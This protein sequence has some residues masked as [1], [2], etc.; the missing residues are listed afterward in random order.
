MKGEKAMNLTIDIS[1]LNP[2]SVLKELKILEAIEDNEKL[3]QK[4]LSSLINVAPSM[5]NQYLGDMENRGLLT[6]RYISIKNVTYHISKEGIDRKNYLL[7]SYLYEL[8]KYY[9]FAKQNIESFFK[10][11]EEKKLQSILL[12]G[13]GEVAET[14][15]TIKETRKDSNFK[16]LAILDDDSQKHGKDILGCEIISPS[17]IFEYTADALIITSMAFE[18]KIKARLSELNYPEEK[19]INVLAS[20][21]I[22]DSH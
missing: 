2:T 11:I 14:L 6:R 15:I 19:L 4:E 9:N 20:N 5:I 21:G 13:A 3:T 8:I 22:L 12:Y 17:R 18:D 10:K 1:F 7:M 16:I